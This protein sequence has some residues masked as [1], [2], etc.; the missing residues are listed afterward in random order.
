[1]LAARSYTSHATHGDCTVVS[2]GII[3]WELLTREEPYPGNTGLQLAYDVA[4]K[5][6]RPSIPAY[7][8][9]EYADIMVRVCSS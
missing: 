5:G 9:A 4:H 7:C 1:M 3:L 8:P 6:L 2:F